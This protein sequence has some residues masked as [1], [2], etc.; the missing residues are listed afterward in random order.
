MHPLD[1]VP[2]PSPK[3]L[4]VRVTNDAIRQ[5]RGG[6]P[7]L[8]DGSIVAVSGTGAAGD[9]AVVFDHDRQFVAIGLY[10][11]ASPIRVRILHQGKPI[12]ID[13]AFWTGLVRAS[14]ERRK[15]VLAAGD[16]TGYRV[17]HGENDGL[18]GLVL[19]RYGDTFVLKLYT[20][21]WLPHLATLLPILEAELHPTALVVRFSRDVAG[22]ELFG[23]REGTMLLGEAPDGPV[24][25]RE[26]GLT[27]E[28][29]V[30]HGQKTGHFLDQRDNR[31]KVRPLAK[32]GRV[33][34]LFSCTGGFSVSAA[35]G[36]AQSVHSVDLS[37]AALETAKRNMQHNAFIKNVAAC[38]HTTQAADVFE[39][40]E[41]YRSQKRLFDMII[42]DPPS[43]ARKNADHDRAL[44]AYR[45]LTRLALD[46]VEN[47]GILVQSS[48]SSRVTADE[49]FDGVHSAAASTNHRLSEMLRTTHAADHPIG[50]PEGAYLKTIFARVHDKP[51]NRHV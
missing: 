13:D 7:W 17:I 41:T 51:V 29:D 36:G 5:I 25:F 31:A 49:F 40:L 8:F 16:T 38:K 48:C 9:L 24:L 45:R 12:T 30:L 22:Q 3:R 21:A 23:L 42:V 2:A 11:P 10:D 19:D 37:S 32:G 4:A 18:S 35:A 46:L 26:H 20:A 43:F 6:H 33:L 39:V 15:A 14:I 1:A 50:F 28:A 44:H 47:G 34:D 27:F